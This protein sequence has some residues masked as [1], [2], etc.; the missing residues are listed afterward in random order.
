MWPV[1][2]LVDPGGR[3]QR[4]GPSNLCYLPALITLESTDDK[5]R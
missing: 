4:E 5:A 1:K 3:V 2:R